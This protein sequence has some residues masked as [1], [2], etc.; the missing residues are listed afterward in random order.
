[1]R[2]EGHLGELTMLTVDGRT[3]IVVLASDR[4]CFGE[5]LSRSGDALAVDAPAL[6]LLRDHNSADGSWPMTGRPGS[7]RADWQPWMD[8]GG[9]PESG[10]GA[11]AL[12]GY[13]SPVG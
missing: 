12:T 6:E 2:H 7:A 13:L 3:V 8:Y 9:S 10:N 4:A 1:M 5:M 11:E